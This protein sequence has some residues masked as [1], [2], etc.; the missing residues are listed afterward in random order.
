MDD[1]NP[2]GALVAAAGRG[3]S[4]AWASLVSRYTPLVASVIRDHRLRGSDAEDVGQTVWLRLVENLG[5][6]REPQALPMWIITTTRNECLRLIR[7]SKRMRP[8]DPTDERGAV[9]ATDTA[10]PDERLLESER[11]R[12][13][14]TAFAELP[15]HQ[16]EL[17]LL[18]VADPPIP[19]AEISQRLGIAIGSI[20]PTRARALQ[21]LRECSSIA[22]Y[23]DPEGSHDKEGGRR[24]V[25]S[26]ER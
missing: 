13:L 10:Q 11:H 15:E 20:G 3:D 5:K 19:Y 6:L 24:G 26:V 9:E 21:R 16:R 8:F 7:N 22:R 1:A 14:L 4:A 23:R 18:L 25:A 17:M 2:I 12:A